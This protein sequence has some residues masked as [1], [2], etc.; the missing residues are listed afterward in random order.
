MQ[1]LQ[2]P[3]TSQIEAGLGAFV[4]LALARRYVFNASGISVWCAVGGL[5]A[6]EAAKLGGWLPDSIVSLFSNVSI[7]SPGQIAAAIVGGLS[8]EM[9]V[10]GSLQVSDF[11]SVGGVEVIV[12]GF[13]A[14]LVGMMAA[15]K[16]ASM[17]ADKE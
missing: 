6:A 16:I 8:L 10:R 1:S 3:Y 2:S 5:A 14:S 11:T 15:K 9:A 7:A 4:G 12:T 17:V 13:V